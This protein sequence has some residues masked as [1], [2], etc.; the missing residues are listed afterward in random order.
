MVIYSSESI[1]SS[2]YTWQCLV[3]LEWTVQFC[4]FSVYSSAVLHCDSG[5]CACFPALPASLI[6][7]RPCC[8]VI[9]LI[10]G[11]STQKWVLHLEELFWKNSLVSCLEFERVL[12]GTFLGISS[13][14]LIVLSG[15]L[16]AAGS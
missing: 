11:R 9:S 16:G 5:I 6:S 15:T 2:E 12:K 8:S 7:E 4:F 10:L 1:F 14:C 3:W 13:V